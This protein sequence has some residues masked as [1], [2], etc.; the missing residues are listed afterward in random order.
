MSSVAHKKDK[1]E[2]F[3]LDQIDIYAGMAAL[4]ALQKRYSY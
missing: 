1:G 3:T 4:E 2:D